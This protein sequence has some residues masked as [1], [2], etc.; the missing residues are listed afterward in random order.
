MAKV[1][2]F[3]CVEKVDFSQ[4]RPRGH[5]TRSE[6]LKRYFRSMQW[7]QRTGL[8]FAGSRRHAAV[9]ALL[10]QL[11]EDT[12]ASEPWKRLDDS[13]HALA[14]FSDSLNPPGLRD[15]MDRGGFV[16]SDLYDRERFLGFRDAALGA[17]IGKQQINSQVIKWNPTS[18]EGF[19]PIPPA[20]HV[21]GQRFIVDSLV[22]TNVVWDRVPSGRPLP[23]PLDAWFVLGNRA[24]L[25]LLEGELRQWGY[26]ANLAALDHLVSYYPPE[27]WGDNLYNV[28]LSSLRALSADTTGSRYP[29]VMRTE[30][31]DRRMLHAQLGSWAQ[32]RRDFILYAKPS[33]GP[34]GCYYP[35]GWV[36]PYP[37]FYDTLAAFARRARDAFAATGVDGYFSNLEQVTS[38]LAGIARAELEGTDL[39]A[40]QTEFIQKLLSKMGGCG[41]GAG[42]PINRNLPFGFDGWY[43]SIIFQVPIDIGEGFEPTIADVHTKL[44]PPP[45]QVLHVGTGYPNLML[46]SVKND[47]GLRSYAG[48]VFSYH[49]FAVEGL[50][51]LTDEEWKEELEAGGE[52]RPAWTR[53][54]IR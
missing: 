18:L 24:A 29:P 19:T 54:F 1:A 44:W 39:T 30:T 53:E 42:G 32:L 40:E 43:P 3:G 27:F 6:A 20:F 5:Y 15:F 17:G 25:P 45:I 14:G 28:W 36:D 7:V 9:A 41:W 51:R 4:F 21:L 23:S 35:D 12:G 33:Y 31:W 11:L 10:A 34:D 16:L 46:I 49:E 22:F 37:E 52:H 2:L 50:T 38:Q 8:S 47:C 26:Q 13:I 48:P